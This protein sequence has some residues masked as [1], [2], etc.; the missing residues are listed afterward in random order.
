V[1]TARIRIVKKV[2][3]FYVTWRKVC[4]PSGRVRRKRELGRNE[5]RYDKGGL[6]YLAGYGRTEGR[7]GSKSSTRGCRIGRVEVGHVG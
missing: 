3:G 7:R 2:V 4:T 6:F 1:I 5:E